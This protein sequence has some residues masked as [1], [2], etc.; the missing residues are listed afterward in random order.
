MLFLIAAIPL[1]AAFMLAMF[2]CGCA[3]VGQS[4]CLYYVA[5][6][7]SRDDKGK[8]VVNGGV[9]TKDSVFLLLAGTS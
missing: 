7:L 6:A 9:H 1:T 2:G 8:L 5:F 4:A 3:I